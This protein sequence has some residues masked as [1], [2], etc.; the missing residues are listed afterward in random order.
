MTKRRSSHLNLLEPLPYNLPRATVRVETDKERDIRS[1]VAY[2]CKATNCKQS[3]Q[4]QPNVARR[5]CRTMAQGRRRRR[6][7][8]R[9]AKGRKAKAGK[10]PQR[11]TKPKNTTEKYHVSRARKERT[12]DAK[13]EKNK[14]RSRQ[15]MYRV[16][17]LR[18]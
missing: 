9:R 2:A 10:I 17:Q 18:R 11:A 8:R 5:I 1:E 14:I 4:L 12:Q 13:K 3:N 7:K 6:R 16:R 15:T